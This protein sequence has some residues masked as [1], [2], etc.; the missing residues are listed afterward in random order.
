MKALHAVR[1]LTA[2]LVLLS[3]TM[4]LSGCT[5]GQSLGGGTKAGAEGLPVTL[6]LG[7]VESGDPP[8][9]YF[10]EEFVRQ[11]KTRSHG[12][13]HVEVDWQL[14]PYSPASEGE[15]ADEVNAGKIDLALVPDRVLSRYGPSSID[16][17]ATPFL[18]DSMPLADAVAESASARSMLASLPLGHVVGL[19]LIPEDLRH[20]AGNGRA[21]ATVAD[22]RQL[23][24]RTLNEVVEPA[25]WALLRTIGAVPSAPKNLPSALGAG[26]LDG[27]ETAYPFYLDFPVGTVYSA[28]LTLFAKFNVLLASAEAMSRLSPEQQRMLA[29]AAGAA[30]RKAAKQRPT[31]AEQLETVCAHGHDAIL[32]SPAELEAFRRLAA[33]LTAKMR[34]NRATAHAIDAIQELKTSVPA[35]APAVPDL[36][37]APTGDAAKYAGN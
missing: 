6:R 10:V 8:Y 17:L 28:N 32:V 21:L 19:A 16:A 2:S 36:C 9:K 7:T 34:T 15:L 27:F 18:I 22:F 31:E 29:D 12:S 20:P 24:I 1:V 25:T 5:S 26:I 37:G 3:A 11:I 35:V 33:P 30:R 4:T 13:V 23:R 14:N